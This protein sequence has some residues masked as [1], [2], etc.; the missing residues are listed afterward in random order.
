VV[1]THRSDM[2]ESLRLIV[3]VQATICTPGIQD[4]PLAAGSPSE[5]FRVIEQSRAN[6]APYRR[7]ISNHAVNDKRT[8][9]LFLTP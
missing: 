1:V 7:P 6:S 5:M 2:T 4:E 8:F 3:G 9:K